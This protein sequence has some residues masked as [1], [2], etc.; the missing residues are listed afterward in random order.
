MQDADA[1]L[2]CRNTEEPKRVSFKFSLSHFLLMSPLSPQPSLPL[3]GP[4]PEPSSLF[5]S[6][7][8]RSYTLLNPCQEV[9]RLRVAGTEHLEGE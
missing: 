8:S 1:Q 7:L 9:A 3:R 5:P 6:I 2:V 4:N